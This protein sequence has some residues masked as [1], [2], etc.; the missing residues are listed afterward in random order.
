MR[1]AYIKEEGEGRGRGER[2]IESNFSL[3]ITTQRFKFRSRKK[4]QRWISKII[5]AVIST[6]KL[7]E[8]L[9]NSTFITATVQDKKY[10]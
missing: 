4:A 7:R 6:R 8:K 10:L 3:Y 2:D 5:T 1:S 9:M